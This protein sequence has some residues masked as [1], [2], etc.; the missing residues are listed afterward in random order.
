MPVA[1]RF[2]VVGA[3]VVFRVL[4]AVVVVVVGWLWVLTMTVVVVIVIVVLL[5]SWSCGGAFPMVMVVV[6][7]CPRGVHVEPLSRPAVCLFV[8]GHVV[9]R[10]LSSS[11]FVVVVG[12]VSG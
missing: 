9:G 4:L 10:V 3:F 2:P 12:N 7:A 5:R 6:V 11:G 8:V 1:C